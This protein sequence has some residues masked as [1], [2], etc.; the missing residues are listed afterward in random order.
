MADIQ[1]DSKPS[2]VAF[3]RE[4][5]EVVIGLEVHVQ[6]KT[7]S[8]M[9]GRAPY[10]Y[11][12]EPNTLTDAVVW[13]FPGTLPVM[14]LEAIRKT[15]QVGCM[16]N[17]E[18]AEI[19]KWDRKHYFYPDLPK[20]YQIS[21]YDKPLC[22]GGSVEIELEG[23][24]RNIMGEH[25]HVE[26]TRIHLEEDVGKLTHYATESLV[27]YNRAGA[28][29]IEIVT[30]PVIK[31][32][33]EAFAFLTALRTH[34]VYAGMSDC[35]MEKGQMRCDANISIRPKG[36]TPLGTKVEIKNLNTISGVRSGILYEI[37]RQIDLVLEGRAIEQQTRRW[38][39]QT[40]MTSPMR[41]KERAH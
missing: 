18:I 1:F 4:D 28:A 38:D 33:D 16:F 35:D 30:E 37:E 15:V 32:A 12:A 13:A 39:A 5:F 24:A 8:K 23:S 40:C 31:S 41:S 22:V 3:K 9:F 25:K 17:C 36:S 29:L 26:L 2:A 21:Q 27:D 10:Y 7:A 34:M 19:C 11:G 20:G 14:N 6:L